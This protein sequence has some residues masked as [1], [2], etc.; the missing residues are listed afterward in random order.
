MKM[1]SPLHQTTRS[2]SNAGSKVG[3][4]VAK[5]RVVACIF[6]W[7]NNFT[8]LLISFTHCL[9]FVYSPE[10]TLLARRREIVPKKKLY[11]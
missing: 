8:P 10:N 9:F 4:K 1:F 7:P 3:A 6:Y 2:V 5:L 11:V